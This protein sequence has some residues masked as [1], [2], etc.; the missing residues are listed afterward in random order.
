MLPPRNRTYQNGIMYISVFLGVLGGL[1]ALIAAAAAWPANSRKEKP[2]SSAV[3]DIKNAG[4]GR[5]AKSSCDRHL[6]QRSPA[7]TGTILHAHQKKHVL[8]MMQVNYTCVKSDSSR[9]RLP[10]FIIGRPAEFMTTRPKGFGVVRRACW[11]LLEE[12]CARAA[13]ILFRPFVDGDAILW[14]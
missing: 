8:Q 14:R 1:R 11:C 12:R 5:S 10:F 7:L 2:T 6:A 3:A 9:P 4:E 13:D